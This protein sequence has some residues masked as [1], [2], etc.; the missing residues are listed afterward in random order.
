M[1]HLIGCLILALIWMANPVHATTWTIEDSYIGGNYA[2]EY[3]KNGGDVIAINSSEFDIDLMNVTIETNGDVLVQIETQYLDGTLG[4]TYGDLFVSINGWNPSGDSS[5]GY[6]TDIYTTG[7]S[8]EF[9]L[10]TVSGNMFAVDEDNIWLSD[11]EFYYDPYSW[12]RHD[13]E[14]VYNPGADEIFLPYSFGFVHNTD[15]GLIEYAFNLE[16]FGLT[17]EDE[18]DLGFHWAMTCAN[19]VIEGGIHKAAVPEPGTMLLL[20]LGI[21]GLG[22]VG[23]KKRR[24]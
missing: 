9:A 2:Q 14:V 19:D 3:A 13:Q 24:T 7:E 17:W 22:A 10:N 18:L 1:R 15:L 4:T 6:S 16:A 21:M 11:D 8:W 12:Y 5:S 20:G 23:R